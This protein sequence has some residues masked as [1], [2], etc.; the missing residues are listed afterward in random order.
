MDSESEII[1]RTMNMDI[2]AIMLLHSSSAQPST[3]R[4]GNYAPDYGHG[5]PL[6]EAKWFSQQEPSV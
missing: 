4:L 1:A 3:S 5:V 2:S 6:W